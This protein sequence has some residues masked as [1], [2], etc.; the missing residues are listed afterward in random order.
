MPSKKNIIQPK[1]KPKQKVPTL[2]EMVPNVRQKSQLNESNSN[3]RSS[4][5]KLPILPAETGEKTT[6]KSGKQEEISERDSVRRNS[7][8]VN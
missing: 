4:W 5:T 3:S 2:E 1:P 6:P 7:K 8:A